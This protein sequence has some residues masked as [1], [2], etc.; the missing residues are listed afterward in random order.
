MCPSPQVRNG[1]STIRKVRKTV[2]E[3]AKSLNILSLRYRY[4]PWND[5]TA[6]LDQVRPGPALALSTEDT[7]LFS[8]ST[9]LCPEAT[10][11]QS[12]TRLADGD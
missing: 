9:Q 10:T 8:N 6:G 11:P 2:L 3:Y 7:K 1:I 12:T 4:G 5:G